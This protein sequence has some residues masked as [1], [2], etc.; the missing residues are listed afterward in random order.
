VGEGETVAFEAL[1][2]EGADGRGVL[3]VGSGRARRAWRGIAPGRGL[4]RCWRRR[5]QGRRARARSASCHECVWVAAAS[6]WA[7]GGSVA[8][9]REV[10]RASGPAG[11]T[12]VDVGRR[13]P[14]GFGPGRE[15]QGDGWVGP[16]QERRGEKQGEVATAKQGG[17]RRLGRD[18]LLRFRSGAR[19]RLL[20][21]PNWAECG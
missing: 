12:A 9:M 6:G 17:E 16:V 10:A 2:A 3:G 14:S 13:A 4:W 11:S 20:D 1:Y 15:R 5:V 19:L 18:R 8:R 21:G 7:P